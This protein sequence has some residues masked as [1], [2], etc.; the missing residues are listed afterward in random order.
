MTDVLGTQKI[1]RILFMTDTGLDMTG[2]ECDI[3]K[4]CN[5]ESEKDYIDASCYLLEY[6]K[7]LTT[8]LKGN[9][10]LVQIMF[11]FENSL[12]YEGLTG[13][14]KSICLENSN[15]DIQLLYCD[16]I[17]VYS[18]EAF[19]DKEEKYG[20]SCM[21]RKKAGEYYERTYEALSLSENETYEKTLFKD[22][23][24]YLITG[25]AGG[26]GL[27]FA[28]YIAENT[29]NAVI[30]LTG[31]SQLNNEEVEERVSYTGNGVKI[32]YRSCDISD[33][34]DVKSLA[35]YIKN[36]FGAVDG[37][38]HSAGIIRDNFYIKK[39]E[40]EFISV[41][42]PK[43]RGIANIDR[44]FADIKVGFFLLMSSSACVTG[45]IGQTDYAAA[46]GF[47]DAYTRMHNKKSSNGVMYSV[48]WPL[49]KDGGM[50]VD[51]HTIDNI[52]TAT[53][54]I[55]LETKD[56]IRM[57]EWAVKGNLMN[58]VPLE[59][60]QVRIEKWLNK[61]KSSSSEESEI[62]TYEKSDAVTG[63]EADK[64][65]LSSLFEDYLKKLM[66]AK[67]EIPESQI[68]AR[69]PMEDFGFTSIMTLDLIAAL[70]EKFGTLSKTL[71]F[72]Y[73]TLREIADYFV[74][75]YTDTVKLLCMKSDDNASDFENKS[76]KLFKAVVLKERTGE[77]AYSENNSE[78]WDIA[79][80]GLAGKYACSN[81]INELWNNL[82]DGRDCISEI[83]NSRWNQDQYYS[84][85]KTDENSTYG[86]WGGFIED[87][88]CFDPRFFRI[89]K[90]EAIQSDPQERQFLECVYHAMEDAGYTRWN[91]SEENLNGFTNDVGVFVG[92][93]YEEYQ[94]YG[95]KAQECGNYVT[96]TGSEASIA[97]RVSYTYGFHG[98]CIALDSMCSSSLSAITL[99]CRSILSNE[100][101]MAVAGGVNLS[102]HPNKF[103]LLGGSRF[104]STK[105]RCEAFAKGGD[106]YVPG[107][108]VGAVIL[109][110]LTDAKRDGDHIYG[111]IKGAAINHCGKTNGYTVPNPKAQSAVIMKAWQEAK[112]NPCAVSYIEAHGTGTAL[113]DPIEI[114]GI[115]KA[116]E[117]VTDKKQFV[118]IGSV[119]SNIGHCE[120]AAGIAGLTKVLLQMKHRKIVPS[121]HTKELN[122]NIDFDASAC[123]VAIEMSEWKRPVINE[124]GREVEYP[125]IAGISAF[126]AG[127]TNAHVIVEEYKENKRAKDSSKIGFLVLSAKST[128]QIKQKANDLLEYM[129]DNYDRIKDESISLND[130]AY[131]LLVG[132]EAMEE[133]AAFT[134]ASVDDVMEKLRILSENIGFNK[135]LD[136][137]YFASVDRNK[138][139][140]ID[141]TDD[142]TKALVNSFIANG[143]YKALAKLFVEGSPVNWQEFYNKSEYGRVSLPLYPFDKVV[144][145]LPDYLMKRYD[146]HPL[147]EKN[148][149]DFEGIKYKTTLHSQDRFM[150]DHRVNGIRTLPAVVYFE[151]VRAAY[152]NALGHKGGVSFDDVCWIR[153][154]TIADEASL[155][156]YISFKLKSVS[157]GSNNFNGEA[158]S[159]ADFEVYSIYEND[160]LLYCTGSVNTA[161]SCNE[162][163]DIAGILNGEGNV[164]ADEK[165][166]YDCFSKSGL[167]YGRSQQSVVKITGIQDGAIATLNLPDFLTDE[168]K[169]Y[170]T[171]PSIMDGA[172]QASIG[173]ERDSVVYTGRTEENS[174]AFIPFMIKNVSIYSSCTNRMY[175]LLRKDSG[176][177]DRI[178]ISLCDADGNVCVKFNKIM[179]KE[180]AG[181]ILS[182]NCLMLSPVEARLDDTLKTKNDFVRRIAIIV[183]HDKK[184]CE[185]ARDSEMY[186]YVKDMTGCLPNMEISDADS[187]FGA[188]V[189]IFTDV[190]VEIKNLLNDKVKG[191]TL[192]QVISDDNT[193]LTDSLQGLFKTLNI[194]NPMYFG[195]CITIE[196]ELTNEQDLKLK[197]LIKE[198]G[199]DYATCNCIKIKDHAL[200][201][202]RLDAVDIKNNNVQSA[203]KDGGVYLITGGFGGIGR[204]FAEHI[205]QSVKNAVV[206]LTARSEL[207]DR[208]KEYLEK[209]S[210]N[211]STCDFIRSDV[212]DATSCRELIDSIMAKYGK[213][214]GI[215]H[216]AGILRDNFIIRKN[217]EEYREVIMPKIAGALNLEY[218]SRNIEL[219]LFA[220]FSSLTGITGNAGQSDYAVGNSFMDR[221]AL[222]R[223][224]LKTEGLRSGKTMS[225]N[226]PFWEEGGMELDEAFIAGMRNRSGMEPIKTK[227][228]LA[229]FDYTFENGYVRM[230]PLMGDTEKI[231][232]VFGCSKGETKVAFNKP[233]SDSSIGSP[234]GKGA[235][236]EYL[237]SVFANILM[238][239]QSDIKDDTLFEELG[240]NSVLVMKITDK[241]EE[242][243]GALPKTVLFESQNIATLTDTLCNEYGFSISDEKKESYSACQSSD[244]V[245]VKKDFCA[246]ADDDIAIIGMSGIFAMSDDLN[247][248]WEN[249]KVGRDCLT[250]IPKDRWDV[251]KYH[252]DNSDGDG[253]LAYLKYGGFI[254][255]V[256]EFDPLFFGIT[257]KY[258]EV[259]DP[260]EKLFLET[261]YHAMED[262]GYTK[263]AMGYNP[264]GAI[265][266]RVGVYVGVMN[267]EYQLWAAQEQLK[268]NPITVSG[269]SASVANRISG[270]FDFHG[271]SLALNTMC[272]SALV[273]I[274]LACDSIKNGECDMSVAGGV[275]VMIHPNEYLGIC[276]GK[277][278]SH[279]GR[280]ASFAEGA[281]GY[282]PGE[283]S[284]AIILK[285]RKMAERDH[286]HIYALIKGIAVNHGGKTSGYTVPNPVAQAD[287]IYSALESA[288]I[289]ARYVSYIEAHG[290]GTELGD[291]IE[292][293][294]L[295]KAF[296]KYTDDRKFCKI[297][298]IKSNIGHCESASG[299]ASIIKVLL[300]MKYK[301]LV[302][303]IHADVLNKKIDFEST[304]F[305]L[306]RETEHWDSPLI[307]EGEVTRKVGRIAGV[308]SFG[309]GGTN[310][311]VVLEEYVP[312]ND[313]G[314]ATAN[315][316]DRYILPISAKVRSSVRKMVEN[317]YKFLLENRD[318]A[319]ED[320]EYTLVTG[321]EHFEEM[322]VFCADS[323]QS[324][325]ELLSKYAKGDDTV[326]LTDSKEAMELIAGAKL[327]GKKIS[328]PGYVFDNSRYWIETENTANVTAKAAAVNTPNIAKASIDDAIMRFV[329]ETVS[330]STGIPYEKIKNKESFGAYGIDSVNIMSMT[331]DMEAKIGSLPK[332]IFYEYDSVEE[333]SRFLK[334]EKS[335]ELLKLPEISQENIENDNV[336]S[337]EIRPLMPEPKAPE[338]RS[339]FDNNLNEVKDSEPIAIIGI[340]GRY[341]M[342]DNLEEFWNNLKDGR[343]CITEI[344]SHRFD[345]TKYYDPTGVTPGTFYSKWG[346]FINDIEYF[347]P[348]LFKIPNIEAAYTDPHERLLLMTVMEALEDAG[349]TGKSLKNETVSVYAG[350]MYSQYQLYA[351]E[352]NGRKIN[353]HSSMSSIANRISYS[354][355]FKG[356]SIAM[357]TMC[358]SVLTALSLACESIHAGKSTMAVIG[359]V[360]LSLHPFK[361]V[362]LCHGN[363]L[364]TDG[365]CRSFGEGGD[366]YVPGEGC[367]AI[368][369][370]PLSRAKKD[371]DNI[372]AVI[373][374]IRTNACGNTSGYTVPSVTA[375]RTLIEETL[376]E[377]GISARQIGAVE[378]HGTGTKLGDPIEIEA[379]TKAYSEYDVPKQ[380]ISIGSVK[381]NIGHLEA[382]SGMASI[383]KVIL[384][385]KNGKLAPTLHSDKPN[386]F[387]DF[388]NSPFYLQHELKE[389]P[390]PIIDGVEGKRC[391]AISAFGAGGS[392]A[393]LILEEY[394]KS[395][396]NEQPE[397]PEQSCNR[398][399]VLSADSEDRLKEYAKR[400]KDYFAHVNLSDNKE[401]GLLKEAASGESIILKLRTAIAN[402]LNVPAEMLNI[403]DTLSDIGVDRYTLDSIGDILPKERIR[404]ITPDMSILD[405]ADMISPR[406]DHANETV[407]L[408]DVVMTLAKGRVEMN[409]RLAIE[410]DCIEVLEERL[411]S[412]IEGKEDKHVLHGNIKEAESEFDNMFESDSFIAYITGEV[413]SG[414]VMEAARA[415]IMGASLPWDKIYEG[416]SANHISLPLY[417]VRKERCWIF[418]DEE[419]PLFYEESNESKPEIGDIEQKPIETNAV[420]YLKEAFHSVLGIP[421]ENIDEKKSYDEYGIDSIYI[422]KL[423]AK[424]KM[425][426]GE[427]PSTLFFSYKN[428]EALAGYLAEHY[429]DKFSKINNADMTVSNNKSASKAI[430]E[431]NDKASVNDIAII[432][433]C[434][435]FPKADNV[436][437]YFEN[438]KNGKDCISE[439]PN[440]RWNYK[441][442]PDIKCRWGGFMENVDQFDPR[443]FGISPGMAYFMDPQE[444]L[445]IETV[446]NCMEDAGYTVKSMQNE[447]DPDK[448]GR[449]AVYA[450][451]SFNEYGMYGASQIAQG[452]HVS[453]SSQIYSVANRVSYL[454]NFGGPSLSVDTACSSS[455]YAVHLAC[456]SL[457]NND[458]D[459]AIAGGVSLS[460]HP[461]KYITLNEGKFLSSDGH[462]H[463]FMSDGDG[464]VPGEGCGAVLLKPLWKAKEDNDHIYGVIKASAVNHGGKT[465]GYT[466][467]NPTA[468]AEVISNALTKAGIN[469]RT[470]SYVEAHGT[471]TKL[472]DPIEVNALTDVYRKYT[473][474]TGYC[475]IG[476]VK[477]NIGHL[478]AAAGISQLIKV[479]MQL[480]H[481]EI[482]P[483]LKNGSSM[484]PNINFAESPFKTVDK[485]TEWKRPVIDDKSY[486][487]RAAISSFGVGGV[488]VHVICEEYI[489]DGEQNDKNSDMSSIN[490]RVMIP[491]YAKSKEAL[492]RNVSRFKTYFEMH[493]K[494]EG[495]LP[496][497]RDVSYTMTFGR[498]VNMFR[499]VFAVLNYEEFIKAAKDYINEIDNPYVYTGKVADGYEGKTI[500]Y[501]PLAG[502]DACS[503]AAETAQGGIPIYPDN[504]DYKARKISLPGYDFEKESYWMY[505]KN[506]VPVEVKPEKELDDSSSNTATTDTV[507]ALKNAFESDRKGI[508]TEYLK[509]MFGKLLSFPE[510]KLPDE[511]EGF[512]SMGLE[513][514]MTKQAID[515]LTDEFGV[516]LSETV[517]FNN[518]NIG[519]LG[520]YLLEHININTDSN[521]YDLSED[522]LA[523]ML[524]AEMGIEQ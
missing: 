358:S 62:N 156:V 421:Y 234:K 516:E 341:P 174:K 231:R 380:S 208:K 6:F 324:F 189:K 223:N 271:P 303:S 292:I 345:Y 329:K 109:K 212:S 353:G 9:R 438:L 511:E 76:G 382:A 404:D 237:R 462:C 42:N 118:K 436:E 103:L 442:Y 38:I 232:E 269:Q 202:D 257:P 459:M 524:K 213:L 96:L 275:N 241:L 356:E 407:N 186:T 437:E 274:K 486:P 207:D 227:Q 114:T 350:A 55:P 117:T 125:L 22:G 4:I 32:L 190:Y 519:L 17:D 328:L 137:I 176:R 522:E 86:K 417:P 518:S 331:E 152:N 164:C 467:P 323:V 185:I 64:T 290:T 199:D 388:A 85:D 169:N 266:S 343:D 435:R 247:E 194:E 296:R 245:S 184:L 408:D 162:R 412:F 445:F 195:Q 225:I 79:V 258:A 456:N 37:I 155:D 80:I 289:N 249:L 340:S 8:E 431:D 491:F 398:L 464:Y 515:I 14:A 393:H 298:S 46:N 59:G 366:G 321:R 434:G 238:M 444:R 48:N 11:C 25:G 214:N 351:N 278:A 27:I 260:Q 364:S 458:A 335:D 82:R 347:D 403:E 92:V 33:N 78:G 523:A 209:L 286:D 342:A 141:K 217:V 273:A 123:S 115:T 252:T 41:I 469:P 157:A 193:N 187:I 100:C 381:S 268:G 94:L 101:S 480:K 51:K 370:K 485:C 251:E 506:S 383:T 336:Q 411:E 226:W 495:V 198:A 346:G 50:C 172:L 143:D 104:L 455:L 410:A 363:F 521:L 183:A 497:I 5:P 182:K 426:L 45:N 264:G 492:V 126:G 338:I 348:M 510:G 218:A 24:I 317:M 489:E 239:E 75:N 253:K 259:M 472:G 240:I 494:N 81:N 330:R 256:D 496:D 389:W 147:V 135:D 166:V 244:I 84:E 122:P 140:Y 12:L 376:K 39:N 229:M 300:Q 192:V 1:K 315:H 20:K 228:A 373:R 68:D 72:E 255:H 288:K 270:A 397:Q 53:G 499:A 120:S 319:L 387:I 206:I 99:A 279:K 230:V 34:D 83:P 439:I 134:F 15:I 429:K 158:I 322:A 453:A 277:F 441:D 113:G 146:I 357:D 454:F 468:Q 450:G 220:L 332:T 108:G 221:F 448:R 151:M 95:A 483:L 375:Q 26:L 308:S 71:F 97:N 413:R 60:N 161:V 367:G 197:A 261:V 138:T 210:Q 474:D 90:A 327:T 44:A 420:D 505:S 106:G 180:A 294:G 276:Q 31:R 314:S 149:S 23:G 406:K 112:I 131:T 19:Y 465:Y 119:K 283:G 56:A 272:S 105:G 52:Y 440:N 54:M 394:I 309:A 405:I 148:V 504:V 384:E 111:V 517:L 91:L 287:T 305:V 246:D 320:I 500:Q 371:N 179:Y 102:I 163:I 482:T 98:P 61:A 2:K 399:F 520:D 159:V 87:A 248:L 466:V 509:E 344:P 285:S 307:N 49:W 203:F 242:K 334:E 67:T 128:D 313:N 451:V 391:A 144:C 402:A 316:A 422:G 513:S 93:M 295:T 475:T 130:I 263:K 47:L 177:A 425:E 219:D 481:R 29:K 418:N 306:Q 16:E 254:N 379:L 293:S 107:E 452:E 281:D 352:I 77:T 136:E 377:A 250:T 30:V 514:V 170:M 132:R 65:K 10:A 88:D 378:A 460:L 297:G 424:M 243:L 160:K 396:K 508:I 265:S 333:L 284:G 419:K 487:L 355:D 222:Y 414:N 372:H 470:I 390:R 409:V 127:G 280:C 116:F 427:L 443:F 461:S 129:T 89:S 215:L 181:G 493:M 359:G 301:T 36:E 415:Y 302:P 57:L 401:N 310:A 70:E 171:Y 349:Y 433:V 478:E 153:P 58:F 139:L 121:I 28:R 484:N 385:M 110:K 35:L 503:V 325:M 476:S 501:A 490:Y 142:N 211:S 312:N 63:N 167:N 360:N 299:I 40:E 282:V 233:Q 498:A 154:C 3:Y 188:Y 262:A 368:I 430:S 361:F 168:M 479:I 326:A 423:N 291:P 13:F 74:G 354:F 477:A 191:K 18:I 124:D 7:K 236:K 21:I 204:I 432:G 133:R 400:F 457:I 446:Y 447:H 196:D 73:Q 507:L 200:L 392:N 267:E 369:I 69:A 488:N 224:R 304:P 150:T 365:R 175:A 416:V 178:N 318:I 449:V 173:I 471:G 216:M 205:V 145:K 374:A 201:G 165:T 395:E 43:I 235:M 362:Q 337:D 66:S 463:T 311:C 473:D 428:I 512:F 386:P 502:Y 339:G